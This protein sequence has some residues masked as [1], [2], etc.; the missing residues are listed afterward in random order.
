MIQ[1]SVGVWG[2]FSRGSHLP[3]ARGGPDRQTQLKAGQDDSSVERGRDVFLGGSLGQVKFQKE[4]SVGREG[5][6]G[7]RKKLAQGQRP[8]E[9]G[10]GS[11][12]GLGFG[13]FS[14]DGFIEI[15]LISHPL[16]VGD[17]SHI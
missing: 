5:D 1:G 4:P 12:S 13:G 6:W 2:T 14:K 3:R 7:P 9:E 10:M 17:F 8:G 15:H 11:P 16:Q